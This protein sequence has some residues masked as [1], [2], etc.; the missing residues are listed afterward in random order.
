VTNDPIERERRQLELQQAEANFDPLPLDARTARMFG[1]V[2]AAMRR[3]G[4]KSQSRSF[5]ALIAATALAHDLPLY[6]A[7]PTDFSGIPGLTV[8]AVEARPQR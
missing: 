2:A 4:R 7:N 1:S 8:V 5:D 6:T 3:S